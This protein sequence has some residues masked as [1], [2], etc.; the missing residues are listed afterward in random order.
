MLTGKVKIEAGDEKFVSYAGPWTMLAIKALK[1][2]VYAPE[3][4]AQVCECPARILSIA[5]RLYRE[6]LNKSRKTRPPSPLV[7]I[8]CVQMSY[9][10]PALSG[11]CKSSF[12]SK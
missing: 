8:D 1:D 11:K 6:M 2:S 4:T 7:N 3:F 5:K 9:N 10:E 12:K